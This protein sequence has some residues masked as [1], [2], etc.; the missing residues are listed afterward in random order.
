[1]FSW[2]MN[3]IKGDEEQQQQQKE[4]KRRNSTIG[5]KKSIIEEPKLPRSNSS[6][7]Q[8]VRS[9]STQEDWKV[10]TTPLTTPVV[11]RH[12]AGTQCSDNTPWGTP[13]ESLLDGAMMVAMYDYE[14]RTDEDLSFRKGEQLE[15]LKEAR[16][17]SGW[18]YARN[19]ATGLEGYIPLDFVAKLRSIEAEPW[20]FGDIARGECE[21]R[22]LSNANEHG[23]FLIRN[24]ESR[25]NEYS[26]SVRAMNTVNHYRIRIMDHGGFFITRRKPFDS[27]HDLVAYYSQHNDGLCTRLDTPCVS[28]DTPETRGLSHDTWDVWEIPKEQV[29]LGRLLGSGQFGEVYQG[30]W[31]KTVPVAVKTLRPGKMKQQE[32][33]EEAQILK[34][35]RHPRLLQLYA[36][37]TQEEPFYII[38]ELMH[39]GSLLDYL[40]R[41]NRPLIDKVTIGAE[42][43]AG[44][45]FLETKNYVHRDLAARNVLVG[46]NGNVKVADFGLS[47]I[48]KEDEYTAAEGARFPIKW[49]A[50]EAL[51]HN[52]FTT[53][54]DVWSFG[55]LLMEVVTS[56]MI[57]YPEL[58]N[59]EVIQALETGYRMPQPKGC[60]TKLYNM[61]L[62]CWAKKPSSRP[63][64]EDLR[65][66]LDD[67]FS[68]EES[69]Y[70][71]FG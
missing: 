31:N 62:E 66:Q 9:N 53:K 65:W 39:N 64:F 1:M 24:S 40:R 57:P 69:D 13:K 50:P 70:K 67:F 51:R 5:R 35:L 55:V 19:H 23:S 42:V 41:E 63:S 38:T 45:E 58:S 4:Q 32:F 33:L 60:P 16:A 43:A 2:L 7:P 21:R 30:R 10:S 54:S 18:L 52:K 61:M 11:S 46:K 26:L 17:G 3:K 27:L 6:E 48:L 59:V 71:D 29:E 68:I 34:N 12:R 20:Y 22:L 56:G 8:L 15:V 37:C 44:M 49:T 14:G 36:V 28:V 47:R 25:K